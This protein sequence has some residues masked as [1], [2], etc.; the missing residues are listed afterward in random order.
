MVR[1]CGFL[2]SFVPHIGQ[3]V[4]LK[5][6]AYFLWHAGQYLIQDSWRRMPNVASEKKGKLSFE[7]TF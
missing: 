5:L 1:R 4:D 3:L 2:L 6:G 7:A